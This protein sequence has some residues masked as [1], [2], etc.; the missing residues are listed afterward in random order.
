[1]SIIDILLLINAVLMLA[2]EISK[3]K[4]GHILSAFVTQAAILSDRIDAIEK[5]L[6]KL[7]TK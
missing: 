4:Q 2:G 3:S 7:L 1:M 6:I 5:T